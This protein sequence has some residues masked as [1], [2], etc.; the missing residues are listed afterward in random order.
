M[1][2]RIYFVAKNSCAFSQRCGV[3]WERNSCGVGEDKVT[4]LLRKKLA[5]ELT[6]WGY[7]PQG[8]RNR[9]GV[10]HFSVRRAVLRAGWVPLEH[11]PA[12]QDV[13]YIA[14]KNHQKSVQALIV[15]NFCLASSYG[16]KSAP[17]TLEVR[18]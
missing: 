11:L 15:Q 17:K 16:E 3:P 4:K 10:M 12:P 6:K 1:P 8:F 14:T 9:K 7:S 13:S 18:T 2:P 5:G